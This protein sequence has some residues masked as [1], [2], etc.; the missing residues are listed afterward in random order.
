MELRD[1]K[2]VLQKYNILPVNHI[3]KDDK[4]KFIV[5]RDLE[6][7]SE[8]LIHVPPSVQSKIVTKQFSTGIGNIQIEDFN[9]TD[10]N[11]YIEYID[12]CFDLIEDITEKNSIC[13]LFKGNMAISSK[14]KIIYYKIDNKEIEKT[15][16]IVKME[17][18]FKNQ[19]KITKVLEID[20]ILRDKLLE[21]YNPQYYIQELQNI[22][23]DIN[24]L[25]EIKKRH[26]DDFKKIM[27]K[28]KDLKKSLN[29]LSNKE[30]ELITEL[31]KLSQSGNQKVK[32]ITSSELERLY[33]IKL[34]ISNL[35]SE[36]KNKKL[37]YI[38]QLD[39]NITILENKIKKY[40][41]ILV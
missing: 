5:V 19:E 34:V 12:H 37:E 14:K 18:I 39:F 30:S 25:I 17:D 3:F 10:N 1:I 8:F 6:T 26:T 36:V 29:M 31:L 28:E 20:N 2:K 40:Y 32:D 22:K 11:T 27:L 21:K 33:S 4:C 15:L 35:L 24:N 7:T 41:K 9:D 38:Q 16:I 13:K 23:K